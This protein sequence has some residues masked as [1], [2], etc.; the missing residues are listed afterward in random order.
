MSDIKINKAAVLQKL[1]GAAAV[2]DEDLA[3]YEFGADELGDGVGYVIGGAGSVEGGAEDEIG[4]PGAGI[5]E[6]GD[7]A[8]SDGVD[9]NFG[10]ESFRE[11]LGQHDDA[12]FGSAVRNVAGPREDSADVSKIDDDAARLFQERRGGLR[13]EE[14]RFQIGVQRGVPDFLGRV[15]HAG[16]EKIGGAVDEDVEAAEVLGGLLKEAPDFGDAA[17]VGLQE[18]AFSSQLGNFG[19][20]VFGFGLRK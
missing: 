13:A 19:G 15:F 2:D 12:G 17:Q 1:Q 14:G 8:G 3:G 16:G 20:S 10:R 5:A 7:G 9:A 11:A 18:H 4:F 6:Q